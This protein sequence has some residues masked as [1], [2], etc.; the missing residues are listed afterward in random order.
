MS[1]TLFENQRTRG[2]KKEEA[3]LMSIN[4]FEA[5]RKRKQK[6][7][8]YGFHT[9]AN[10]GCPIHLCGPFRDNIRV[11]IRECG[12]IEDYNVDG[13]PTWCTLLVNEK[14]GVVVPLYTIEESVKHS[15]RPFCDHCRCI[16]WSHH[17]VS[18]RR[19][20][21]IIPVEDEWNKPLEEDSFYAHT[22]ILHGLIHCNGFG[23]L[24]CINGIE[25]GSKYLCGREIMDLWDRIC[26]TLGTRKITVEDNSKK[27]SMDLRLLYGVAYGHSWFGRWGY[28][29]SHGSFGVTEHKYDSA[30]EIL[31]S[32][33]LN[34]IVDDF[35]NTGQGR[36]I[37]QIIHSYREVSETQLFTIRGLLRLML[38]LKS[39]APVQR[40][41]IMAVAAAASKSSRKAA[42]R[43]QKSP[44][45][46]KAIKYRKFAPSAANM[47]SRW[48]ARRLEQAAEVIVEA[49]KEK[50][51]RSYSRG[52]MS[53]QDVRDAARQHIGDTGLLDFVLKSL[54]NFVV[55]NHVVRRAVNPSTRVLEYTIHEVSNGILI[56]EPEIIDDPPQALA[57]APLDISPG[58]EP[59]SDVYGDVV[60]LY[61][62]VLLG[63][64]E[65][66]MVE[67]ATGTVLD[68]KHFV[69]EWPFKDEED[70]VLRFICLVMP[71]SDQLETELT[72]QLSL[73]ELVVVPLHS[74]VGELKVA[75][76]SAMRDTYC[77]MERFVAREIAGLEEMEDYEV[78]FGAL[79]S[80]SKLL[81]RGSGMDLTTELRYEGGAENWTVDCCCGAKDDDGERM[82]ACDI[83]E[84]W[85][86]TR[87]GGIDDADTV[88]PLFLCAKCSGSLLSPREEIGMEFDY[89]CA[90]F[91]VPET[92]LAWMPNIGEV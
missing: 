57:L 46:N 11:F 1:K 86:H 24:L 90:S 49:L 35:S 64:P 55:G 13:M 63:Y 53:R 79:E 44:E 39:R 78:L 17:F 51:A 18:N 58:P 19:Y 36:E 23:H 65:S 48:P 27:R 69:K 14:S 89:S 42:T 4:I 80:G 85:Q 76:E 15:Q 54:N 70:P 73:G 5:C 56:T 6:P 29:F 81:V 92:E 68:S 7:K 47:D 32:L 91:L 61:R 26:T 3:S 52:G 84:V 87:C 77:I 21:L 12:E 75:V 66:E 43:T 45:K 37:K 9:F 8:L 10:P 30:I 62:T 88:P 72:R 31:S 41:T 25:G 28:K 74:T 83:C 71:S 22:H 60:Y 50:K 20:H 40:K 34:K 16:G 67:L 38:A 59:G 82:V 2:V 33:D